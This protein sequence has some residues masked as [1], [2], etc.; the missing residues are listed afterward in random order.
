MIGE[1]APDH[2]ARISVSR[3]GSERELNV[4]LGKRPAPAFENGSFAPLM[5]GQ[6]GKLEF[7]PMA[8]MG[9]IGEMPAMPP[10]PPGGDRSGDFY[11]FRSG[12]SRQIGVGVTPLTKQLAQHFSVESGAIINNV[13]ENS[14]AAKA[15]LK[16]GDIIVEADGKSVKGDFDLIRTIGEKK[17]GSINLTI[18]R[19]GSRQSVSVTPEEV[20][21]GMNTF[22]ETPDAPDTPAA[23]GAIQV[24][25]AGT[26]NADAAES[27]N[28]SGTRDL[29]L[30][31]Q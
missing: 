22:F 27:V 20:K 10:I 11:V 31:R 30:S 21:G 7:P 25:L 1:I 17:E 14:P 16:A 12:S 4:T 5:P 28:D 9:P 8:P 13:R 6:P 23:P 2:Q 18:V 26:R 24:C 3:N 19:D 29:D 15:G